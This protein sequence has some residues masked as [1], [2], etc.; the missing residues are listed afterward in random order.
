MHDLRTG[1]IY[2]ND[3]MFETIESNEV[4]IGGKNCHIMTTLLTKN[5]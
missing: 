2:I 5:L 4:H 3:T 1:K